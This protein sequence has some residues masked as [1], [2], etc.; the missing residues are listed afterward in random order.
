MQLQPDALL[1][2]QVFGSEVQPLDLP[3]AFC[4]LDGQEQIIQALT[5]AAE[6]VFQCDWIVEPFSESEWADI[7]AQPGLSL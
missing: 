6:Q 7:I 2:E 4:R 3:A 5:E 1:F